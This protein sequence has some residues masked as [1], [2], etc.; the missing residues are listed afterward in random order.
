MN[1]ELYVEI[2]EKNL[3]SFIADEVNPHSNWFMQD[4]DLKHTSSHVQTFLT[5][6]ISESPD[7]NPIENLW[8]ELKEYIRQEVEPQ[9]NFLFHYRYIRPSAKVI[10]RVIEVKGEPTGY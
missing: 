9:N 8:H 7:F 1:A 10:L 4:N 3:L 6:H 2:L 5:E